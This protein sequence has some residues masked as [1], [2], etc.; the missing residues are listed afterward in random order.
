MADMNIF[1]LNGSKEFATEVAR[2]LSLPL[3]EN[4]EETFD[5]GEAYLR[6]RVNVRGS[7]VYVICSL[8]REPH[9][10]VNDKVQR[11]ILFCSSLFRAS[12][13]K[14]TAVC[15]YLA[16]ARQDRKTESRAPLSL[17]NFAQQLMGA[18]VDRIIAMDVHSLPGY[19]N[20]FDIQTDHLVASRI[21]A[22][23]LSQHIFGDKLSDRITILSPD[24]GG[25]SRCK[26]FR[27]DLEKRLCALTNQEI[28]VEI[29]YYDKERHGRT[30]RGNKIVGTIE[31]RH[32]IIYDDMVV[33]GSTIAAAATAIINSKGSL[34]AVVATHGLFV[35]N[36]VKNLASVPLIVVA[37]TIDPRRVINLKEEGS[38]DLLDKILVVKTEETFA[39]AIRRNHDHDSV[40]ELFDD[41]K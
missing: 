36:A 28:E 12:A 18:H 10:S 2:Y 35:G 15:P 7:D 27:N 39:T 5:D 31:D 20:A 22:K 34:Y 41:E 9:M 32:I 11:L 6:S 23:S 33:T 40:S 26:R 13:G 8:Y 19:E 3:S 21:L 29:A 25:V 30:V 38:Q 24:S 37:N 14:I 4:V 16:Y 1:G 17:K